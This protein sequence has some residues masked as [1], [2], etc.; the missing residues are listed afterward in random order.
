L[1]I[2]INQ[3][4]V[5]ASERIQWKE[6]LNASTQQWPWRRMPMTI[7]VPSPTTSSFINVSRLLQLRLWHCAQSPRWR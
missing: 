2:L 5:I 6:Q 1:T 7:N 4:R 3:K